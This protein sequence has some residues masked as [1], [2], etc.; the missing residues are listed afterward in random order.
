MERFSETMLPD[1]HHFYNRLNDEHISDEKYAH[2]QNIWN[3]F[4]CTTMRDYHDL[5]LKTDIFLLADIFENF[6]EMCLKSYGL[7][8]VH[9]YSLPGLSWD[10]A[11]KYTEVELELI[12]D[13]DMY[14][15]VER[16][17]RGGISMISHRFAEANLPQMDSYN[18]EQRLRTLTYQDA[19]ALYSWAMCQSLPTSEFEWLGTKNISIR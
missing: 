1:K 19:N 12:N 2:A 16:G 8:P 13:I 7:D 15:M 9:Y 11:L 17:I 4:D 10:A 14:Q 3:T 5:Y 18:S 6:R